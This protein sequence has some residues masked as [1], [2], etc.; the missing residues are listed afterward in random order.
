MAKKRFVLV[1]GGSDRD[2]DW[3][4]NVRDGEAGR[5]ELI[6]Q[7]IVKKEIQGKETDSL[8]QRDAGS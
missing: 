8:S 7:A 1:I 5:E 2:S 3:I 4:K 6:V